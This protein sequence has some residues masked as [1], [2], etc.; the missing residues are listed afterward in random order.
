[1]GR[2]IERSRPYGVEAWAD[3]RA[4]FRR[5]ERDLDF[6][7]VKPRDDGSISNEGER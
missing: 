2:Q 6:G 7:Q 5:W 3:L 4:R 1:M